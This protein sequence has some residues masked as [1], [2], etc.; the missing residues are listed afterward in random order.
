MRA[1]QYSAR[2]GTH[3][4]RSFASSWLLASLVS[5]AASCAQPAESPTVADVS[6][7][8]MLHVGS[9]EPSTGPVEEPAPASFAD[10][11]KLL[12]RSR[13][14]SEDTRKKTLTMARRAL[15]T[16]TG[17]AGK[18]VVIAKVRSLRGREETWLLPQGAPVEIAAW[19]GKELRIVGSRVRAIGD[20]V[21][22]LRDGQVALWSE[23]RK[24]IAADTSA[25]FVSL[26]GED[27]FVLVKG[28]ESAFLLDTQKGTA[29]LGGPSLGAT[30]L[31]SKDGTRFLR[32][33]DDGG[34]RRFA[35][36]DL[37]ELTEKDAWSFY[38]GTNEAEKHL[39]VGRVDDKGAVTISVLALPELTVQSSATLAA[40]SGAPRIFDAGLLND[41]GTS[42]ASIEPGEG[43]RLLRLPTGKEEL[44]A[45]ESKGRAMKTLAFTQDGNHLCI[46]APGLATPKAKLV[47]GTFQRCYPTDAGALIGHLGEAPPGWRRATREEVGGAE[48]ATFETISRDGSMVAAILFRGAITSAPELSVAVYDTKTG[49]Q[50]WNQFIESRDLRAPSELW[51]SD[52]GKHLMVGGVRVMAQ[53]GEAVDGKPEDLST[54]DPML[55]SFGMNVGTGPLVAAKLASPI[56]SF[57]SPALVLSA[58]PS[59]LTIYVDP[60]SRVTAIQSQENRKV[61]LFAPAKDGAV[62]YLPDGSFSVS[63][64]GE[65]L[66]CQ[67]GGVLAPI[68]VCR[69]SGEASAADVGTILRNIM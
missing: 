27:R 67:F 1:V 37:P 17:T 64:S 7:K 54:L 63:G 16:L 33:R 49:K 22:S 47:P 28:R 40:P 43:A 69:S 5:M 58:S 39:A 8:P 42:F 29:E 18:P 52:D 4:S 53:N 38:L 6:A 20:K 32:R 60:T 45:R 68:E 46:D 62:A 61:A 11:A 35:R 55:R 50:R 14:E 3:R 57:P 36:F 44:V 12:V 66:A 19:P 25:E 13:G 41:A 30:L 21:V 9:A 56:P 10:V 26:S 31:R 24:Q 2:M 23:G 59:G 48:S 34:K 51:F 15:V 65:D